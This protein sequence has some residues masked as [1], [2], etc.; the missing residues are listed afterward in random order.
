M[1][2]HKTQHMLRRYKQRKTE[3]LT[4]NLGTEL[5]G[6]TYQRTASPSPQDH[7]FMPGKPNNNW[8]NTHPNGI[9]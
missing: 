1:D 5:R 3:H 6:D 4:N 2:S 8:T 7:L 9:A